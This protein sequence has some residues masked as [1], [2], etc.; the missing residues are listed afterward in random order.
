MR[1]HVVTIDRLNE[2]IALYRDGRYAECRAEIAVERGRMARGGG[3][4]TAEFP[5][6]RA[7]VK[8]RC[9]WMQWKCEERMEVEPCG[10]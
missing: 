4:W 8:E 3:D 2:I 6:C 1:G 5:M 10:I 7:F 9:N